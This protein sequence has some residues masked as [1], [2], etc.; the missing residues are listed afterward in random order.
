MIGTGL[1]LLSAGALLLALTICLTA[2][3]LEALS[4]DEEDE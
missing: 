4:Y 1:S 2:V 3:V